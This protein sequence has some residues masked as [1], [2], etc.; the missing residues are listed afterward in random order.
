MTLYI[1]AGKDHYFNT[2]LYGIYSNVD[3]QRINVNSLSN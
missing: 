3:K 1:L 2:A